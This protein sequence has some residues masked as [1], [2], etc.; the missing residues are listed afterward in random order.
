MAFE[1]LYW[2]IFISFSSISALEVQCDLDKFRSSNIVPKIIPTT[3]QSPLLIEFNRKSVTCGNEMTRTETKNPPTVMDFPAEKQK[4]YTMIMF[5]PD[6]LTPQNPN[7]ANFRHWLVENIPGNKVNDGDL[8][9]FYTPPAP[10]DYSD[11][12]RYIF[13]I[14]EQ[15]E[16]LKDNFDGVKRTNFDVKKFVQDRGLK[17]PIAGNFF[18]LK[19]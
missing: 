13:L 17:G 9:S 11:P 15:P 14:Y 3:P 12:H 2:L 1:L 18:Y 4:L 10:P 8:V 19:H 7:L 6:A 5:D 16:K